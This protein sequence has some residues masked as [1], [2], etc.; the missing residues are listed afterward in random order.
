MS[1]SPYE[2][3]VKNAIEHPVTE[4]ELLS[5]Q[6]AVDKARDAYMRNHS[7]KRRPT[8]WDAAQS[9]LDSLLERQRL[10]LEGSKP[11]VLVRGTVHSPSM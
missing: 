9:H 6:R 8:K 5:A 10:S 3:R 2:R 7:V 4:E 1:M 11:S